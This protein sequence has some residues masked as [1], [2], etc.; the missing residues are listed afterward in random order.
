MSEYEKV[1]DDPNAPERL[2]GLILKA[3]CIWK[4]KKVQVKFSIDL[5]NNATPN[6]IGYVRLLIAETG[7]VLRGEK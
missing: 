2:K 1:I 3:E 7:D 5:P 6:E 4:G